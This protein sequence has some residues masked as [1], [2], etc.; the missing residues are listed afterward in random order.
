MVSILSSQKM[1]RRKGVNAFILVFE[2]CDM[3]ETT[4]TRN[5]ATYNEAKRLESSAEYIC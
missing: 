2:W 1:Q 4:N 3:V 5:E